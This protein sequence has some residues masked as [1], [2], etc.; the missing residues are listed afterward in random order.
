MLERFLILI[1]LAIVG[2]IVYRLVTQRQLDKAK[3]ATQELRQLD[4][5]L[6]TL[7]PHI[8]AIVYFTTPGCMPCLTQQQ[9]ALMRLTQELGPDGI[10]IIKVDAAQDPDT[11]QRW[12]VMTAP[13]TFVLGVDGR[14]HAVNNG[15]ADERL[16]K[17]QLQRAMPRSVA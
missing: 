3:R 11:A 12:G 9:P 6:L 10:Q 5:L 15:V 2:V 14:P 16:L 1:V 17:Q 8:P 7:K 4:P 13:T